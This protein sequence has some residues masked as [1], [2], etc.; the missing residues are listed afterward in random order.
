MT[1]GSEV[2]T[3]AQLTQASAVGQK[4]ANFSVPQQITVSLL[5]FA[6]FANWL[7]VVPVIVPD[8]VA[9]ILGPD[10]AAKEGIAG[11]I[12]AIGA[13]MALIMAPLAGAISDRGRGMKGRRRPFLIAGMVGTCVGLALL[14][15]FGQ[16][17]SVFLYLLAIL[18]LQFWWNWA[19]G[20]YAGLIPD[21]VPQGDQASASAWMNIMS[22][23]GTFT[24]NGIAVVL[25]VD[26][27][28]AASIAALSRSISPAWR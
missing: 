16:G 5:W 28:P 22:I 17:S 8:Q 11:S 3:A 18:N 24:G 25:Y 13:V 6:L 1:D 4:A 23:L 9:A 14:V 2:A 15:P 27:R 7:T 26:G 12:L 20:P 10:A 19:C 21:V